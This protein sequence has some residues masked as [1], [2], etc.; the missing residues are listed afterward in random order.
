MFHGKPFAKTGLVSR[1]NPFHTM[2]NEW[3]T[4]AISLAKQAA[5]AGEI[6]VGAVVVKDGRII[7]MGRNNRET[8]HCVTGHAEINA[9][10]EACSALQDWR[11]D[12]CELYVT[13]EP[14]MMCTGAILQSRISRV[15]FGAFDRV[16][17]A[18]DSIA[19]LTHAGFPGRVEVYCGIREQ[20]CKSVL[21]D[22]FLR[23]RQKSDP[24]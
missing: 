7:G 4:Q 21:D 24:E 10:R 2:N 12:G 18:M 23:M 20:E 3:M 15:A 17:G 5:E 1:G 6:P 13:L 8:G 11:L 22:F 14:C 19:D 9:I 16:A